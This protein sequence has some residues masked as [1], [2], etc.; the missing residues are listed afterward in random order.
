MTITLI[1]FIYLIQD[2][3]SVNGWIFPLALPIVILS[4]LAFGISLLAF[5][6]KELNNFISFALTV[7]LFGIIVNIGVGYTVNHY[8]K[9]D[10]VFDIYRVST[11]SA[12]VFLSLIL[13]VIGYAKRKET[14]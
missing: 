10:N 5:A 12:S 14:H 8:L 4:L 6:S 7:F 3:S 9:E 13:V 11:I 1:P 2:Q